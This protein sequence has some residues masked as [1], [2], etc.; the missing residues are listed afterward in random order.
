MELLSTAQP[1]THKTNYLGTPSIPLLVRALVFELRCPLLR[2][3]TFMTF[4][5]MRKW[6]ASMM[7]IYWD[8]YIH[9]CNLFFIFQPFSRYI[10]VFLKRVT[11]EEGYIFSPARHAFVSSKR[12]NIKAENYTDPK[13][14]VF[15][16]SVA[17][18]CIYVCIGMVASA[19]LHRYV[20]IGMFTSVCLHRYVC[21]G[22]FASVCIEP[23][24]YY[25]N[26]FIS[27]YMSLGGCD[28]LIHDAPRPC[29]YF[30]NYA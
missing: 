20:Y 1:K 17:I 5:E 30:D 11:V 25:L 24:V 15:V 14:M 10:D 23:C 19:C 28:T 16:V 8:M 4:L 7:T 29:A 13:G 6:T 12:G 22:M 26:K 3:A 9:F 18:L 27:M 2:Y 21:I